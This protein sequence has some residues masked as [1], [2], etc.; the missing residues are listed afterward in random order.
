MIIE[1]QVHK[2]RSPLWISSR[3]KRQ[4]IP[5]YVIVV[6]WN[7]N[8]S[9]FIERKIAFSL[10]KEGRHISSNLHN[11]KRNMTHQGSPNIS[12]FRGDPPAW[13]V[14]D[15]CCHLGHPLTSS[16]SDSRKNPAHCKLFIS[17]GGNLLISP[18]SCIPRS[19]SWIPQ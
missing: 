16:S 1:R 2:I 6:I 17:Q 15:S 12:G 3:H 13:Y 11:G 4:E 9:P 19:S 7:T 10:T 5:I 18:S 14:S 8:R